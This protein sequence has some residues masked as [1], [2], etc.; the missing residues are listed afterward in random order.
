MEMML[1]KPFQANKTTISK[2][3]EQLS[4]M[5]PTARKLQETN[6]SFKSSDIQTRN[7]I[8]LSWQQRQMFGLRDT[9]ADLRFLLF[10]YCV[11]VCVCVC[12]CVCV[13]VF[14]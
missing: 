1:K 12:L 14:C 4:S 7:S 6:N 13:C 11:C 3:K 10:L 8:M 2:V 5:F 9:K